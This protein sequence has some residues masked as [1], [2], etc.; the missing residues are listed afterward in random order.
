MANIHLT[1]ALSDYDHFRDF[2][3]GKIKAEG[4]DITHIDLPVEEIFFR[5]LR[6]QEFDAA[7][8][9]LSSYCLMLARGASADPDG[10]RPALARLFA[11]Q[12]LSAAPG[13]AQAV[14]Q[15]ADD[16]QAVAADTL[17]SA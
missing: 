7:E 17:A 15:G 2:T 5:M 1:V 12:V 16:L 4:I 13:L 3:G 10:V 14:M 6:G 9:S 8:M 11:G